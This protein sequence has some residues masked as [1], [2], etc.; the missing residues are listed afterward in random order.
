MKKNV[1]SFLVKNRGNILLSRRNGTVP[2]STAS[3]YRI[4]LISLFDLYNLKVL[5]SVCKEGNP[6]LSIKY[7]AK[8]SEAKFS[9]SCTTDNG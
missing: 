8:I 7:Q 1:R 9:L 3:G 6:K 2:M 4:C 5:Q